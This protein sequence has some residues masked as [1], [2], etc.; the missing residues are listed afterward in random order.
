MKRISI[1]I[2]VFNRKEQLKCLLRSIYDSNY[3]DFEVIVVDDG[4]T[5]NLSTIKYDF[6]DIKYIKQNN[7]G[8]GIARNNGVK[9][10][11]GRIIA[12]TDSDCLVSKDWL[13]S[14]SKSFK[15]DV[16]IVGGRTIENKT[17][18]LLRYLYM[19]K[20]DVEC[21]R[22]VYCSTN[23][24]AVLKKAFDDVGGFDRYFNFAAEDVDFCLRVQ[25]HKYRLKPNNDMLI[26]HEHPGGFKGW[27]KKSFNYEPGLIKLMEKHQ[28][29]RR[30]CPYYIFAIPILALK[31]SLSFMKDNDKGLTRLP[32]YYY[33]FLLSRLN[34]FFGKLQY[35]ISKGKLK[36][37]LYIPKI[38]VLE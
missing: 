24:M 13:K 28:Y 22:E 30:F 8:P 33:I 9:K 7:S 11:K 14:I 26:F 20:G 15:D 31:D 37:L 16:G 27:L 3:K 4:S 12:F 18:D 2:P 5:E 1:V 23:N 34:G 35:L 29:I 36:Y 32:I 38:R 6:P 17:K 21:K 10:A 19:P 25:K